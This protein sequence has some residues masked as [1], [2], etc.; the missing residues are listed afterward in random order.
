MT[1]TQDDRIGYGQ[2][3]ALLAEMGRLNTDYYKTWPL[4]GGAISY[5]MWH[6]G[7]QEPAARGY[8]SPDGD[9]RPY[10]LEVVA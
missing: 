7:E 4:P 5:A 3:L 6:E 1:N 2:A 9:L 8:I 10:L